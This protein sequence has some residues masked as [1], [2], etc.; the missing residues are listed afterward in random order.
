MRSGSRPTISCFMQLHF[1]ADMIWRR[2]VANMC[3]EAAFQGKMKAIEAKMAKDTAAA[4]V[5]D[6]KK[7]KSYKSQMGSLAKGIAAGKA[8]SKKIAAD[9]KAANLKLAADQ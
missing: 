9:M 5:A 2:S 1:F 6:A 7:E 8:K 4:K 3:C